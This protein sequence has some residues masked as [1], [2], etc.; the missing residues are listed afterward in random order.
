MDENELK[1]L[2]GKNLPPKCLILTGCDS[3][4]VIAK[5]STDGPGN[6]VDAIEKYILQMT[7][8]ATIC[9]L[10]SVHIYLPPV[11]K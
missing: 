11:I 6:S 4:D 3:P 10:L 5:M 2:M 7:H 8:H 1:V 9:L